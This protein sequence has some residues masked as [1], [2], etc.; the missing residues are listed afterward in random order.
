MLFF[1]DYRNSVISKYHKDQFFIIV[2]INFK[3]SGDYDNIFIARSINLGQLIDYLVVCLKKHTHKKSYYISTYCSLQI[4][5]L[6]ICNQDISKTNLCTY[7][8]HFWSAER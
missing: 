5:A 7:E 6:K 3:K 2:V 4:W 1:V 8:L